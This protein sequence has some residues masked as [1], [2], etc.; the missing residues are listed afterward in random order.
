MLLQSIWRDMDS[1]P[2]AIR[3]D[4]QITCVTRLLTLLRRYIG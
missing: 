2:T 4:R 3:G 1:E